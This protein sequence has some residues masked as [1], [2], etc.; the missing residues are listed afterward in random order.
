MPKQKASYKEPHFFTSGS[1]RFAAWVGWYSALGDKKLA[2][3]WE[4]QAY[5]WVKKE[6]MKKLYASDF[7]LRLLTDKQVKELLKS[8]E[9]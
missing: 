9:D 8:Y 6:E 1:L 4:H 5:K 3:D 2:E 7:L